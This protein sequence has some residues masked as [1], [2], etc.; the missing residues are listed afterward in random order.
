MNKMMMR[1]LLGKPTMWQMENN[2]IVPCF[3]V[4][5]DLIPADGEESSKIR[6]LMLMPDGSKRLTPPNPLPPDNI[7][8]PA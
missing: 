7:A 8:I 4:G 2:D 6:Y 3:V 1:A 5:C